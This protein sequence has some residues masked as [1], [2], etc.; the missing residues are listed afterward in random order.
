MIVY[1]GRK[2]FTL[3]ATDGPPSLQFEI[4][5]VTLGVSQTAGSRVSQDEQQDEHN[6]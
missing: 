3:V 2:D 5:A 6:K 4:T 1:T